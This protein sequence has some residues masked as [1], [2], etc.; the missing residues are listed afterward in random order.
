MITRFAY[1]IRFSVRILSGFDR[2]PAFI[3]LSVLPPVSGVAGQK[4][5]S[6]LRFFSFGVS[7]HCS[8]C[9]AA[10]V[11]RIIGK[12]FSTVSTSVLRSEFF[13][14]LLLSRLLLFSSAP[15]PCSLLISPVSHRAFV[16][17]RSAVK[18]IC[19]LLVALYAA[20][21]FLVISLDFR[22]CH[23]ISPYSGRDGRIRTCV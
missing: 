1:V 5:G 11:G 23:T 21:P 15:Y 20:V 8:A 16:A 13:T 6:C 12:L 10:D 9:I 19:V 22:V 3:A 17:Q 14:L 7:E 4:A 18:C 2:F